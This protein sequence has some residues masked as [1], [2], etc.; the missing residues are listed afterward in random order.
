MNKIEE[1]RQIIE[2]AFEG[3]LDK[4]NKPYLGH[5]LRV[6]QTVLNQGASEEVQCIALLHD[7]LE[8][9]PE[10]T[11]EMLLK[12]FTPRVVAGVMAMTHPDEEDY[13]DYI[14]RLKLNPDAVVVK[15]ADLKDNMNMNRID[16]P[17]DKDL[18]RVEKYRE[19]WRKLTC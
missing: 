1:A 14:E 4:A 6:H 3:I 17:K 8:D 12:R 19:A 16:M 10:W 18:V 13:L 9:C 11:E 15:L 5:L 7:L 2:Q